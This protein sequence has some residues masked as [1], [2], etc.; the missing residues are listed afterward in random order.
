M[1]VPPPVQ[2]SR[3]EV[4]ARLEAKRR[5]AESAG[6]LT[7]PTSLASERSHSLHRHDSR[8]PVSPGKHYVFG[9]GGK[10]KVS[11]PIPTSPP[12][13]PQPPKK[14]SSIFKF[15]AGEEVEDSPDLLDSFG[16]HPRAAPEPPRRGTRPPSGFFE[17]RGPGK[18]FQSQIPVLQGTQPSIAPPPIPA[19]S[20]K[21]RF[22]Q[23]HENV[24]RSYS[25]SESFI[26]PV[27]DAL[28]RLQLDEGSSISAGQNLPQYRSLSV[29]MANLPEDMLVKPRY[30]RSSVASGF[31]AGAK[32][33]R[34][35]SVSAI[36]SSVGMGKTEIG[37]VHTPMLPK[38]TDTSHAAL[39]QYDEPDLSNWK[40]W[41]AQ[42]TTGGDSILSRPSEYAASSKRRRQEEIVSEL[43]NTASELPI[44]AFRNVHE[45]KVGPILPVPFHLMNKDLPA[46]PTSIMATPTEMYHVIPPQPTRPAVRSPKAKNKKR[47]PLSPIS[48]THAKTN[49]VVRRKEDTS[50]SRLSA[51]PELTARSENSP[52]SSGL[53]TPI[54]TQIHLRNGSVV[55]VSPP[56]MTAWKRSHY[57]QGPIKL[58]KPVIVPRKN[59]MASLEAFQQVVDQVYQEALNIPRRRS[60]DAV[61]DDVCEFFDE[62]GFDEINF[63][64][65]ILTADEMII[66]EIMEESG[67]DSAGFS[68]SPPDEDPSPVEKVLAQEIVHFLARP[69]PVPKPPIPP[70]EN[71]ET[72]RAKGIARLTHRM[73]SHSHA[74]I[75]QPNRK[76]S[77]TTSKA[78][79]P[80]LPLP[81]ESM[82]EAVLQPS[83]AEDDVLM[84]DDTKVNSNASGFDW[85]VEELDGDTHW[86]TP[87]VFSRRRRGSKGHHRRVLSATTM[88]QRMKDIVFL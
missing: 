59:S 16:E 33:S 66:D 51:I 27:S 49:S 22:Q 2:L 28:S 25:L 38:S 87:A 24:G 78:E 35:G 77:L 39:I 63:E 3:A 26:R 10:V 58:P 4:A 23:P 42:G 65:D 46:T 11:S 19:K 56:E 9:R 70:V 32:R 48:T 15:V 12:A 62:F 47:S 76:D 55:T 34:T 29:P 50:P 75:T 68:T 54:E 13:T 88:H 43:S 45:A 60:D 40:G 20:P 61:V 72:L 44:A 6:S 8:S 41:D 84:L 80:L 67:Q 18:S 14:A 82:L 53:S 5:S 71:E 31:S 73:A 74:S 1:F 85:D 86:L 17:R 81:E 36:G 37:I 79:L 52:V 57:I 69:S 21:R 30:R 64:G 7:R 83:R